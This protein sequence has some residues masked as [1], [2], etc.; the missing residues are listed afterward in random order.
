MAGSQD[1]GINF[2][3]N[4]Y[5]KDNL[6]GITEGIKQAVAQAKAAKDASDLWGRS[7]D[8]AAKNAGISVK[9][10]NS[11][12]KQQARDI[13]DA[14]R[15]TEKLAA[16]Q[17][18][19]A[20]AE[21]QHRQ[22]IA[23]TSAFEAANRRAQAAA[24][25]AAFSRTF[26]DTGDTV[27]PSIFGGGS[28]GSG[29]GRGAS[30]LVGR[31]GGR[32]LGAEVLGRGLGIPGG[33]FIG[34][35]LAYGAGLSGGAAL[36][37][38]AA[39]VGVVGAYAIYKDIENTVKYAEEQTK[40]AATLG[41]STRETQALGKAAEFSG[42]QI[43]QLTNVSRKLNDSLSSGGSEARKVEVT[44]K[45]LGLSLATAFKR[46]T[47]QL[48]DVFAALKKIDSIPERGRLLDRLFGPTEGRALLGAVDSYKLSRPG[49]DFV[50]D[51]DIT[52]LKQFGDNAKTAWQNVQTLGRELAV[53]SVH[54]IDFVGNVASGKEFKALMELVRGLGNLLPGGSTFNNRFVQGAQA[55][56]NEPYTPINAPHGPVTAEEKAKALS[57]INAALLPGRSSAI[58]GLNRDIAR[59][60]ADR[61]IAREKA[62]N[63][64]PGYT[65]SSVQAI[66]DQIES[67]K[68]QIRQQ[69][70]LENERESLSEFDIGD[71]EQEGKSAA[72]ALTQRSSFK[73]IKQIGTPGDR[74]ALLGKTSSAL[75]EGYPTLTGTSPYLD[76]L[77]RFGEQANSLSLSP[78]AEY[79][80]DQEQKRQAAAKAAAELE[81][82][83]RESVNDSI[84]GVRAQGVEGRESAREG[85]AVSAGFSRYG[86]RPLQI[87]G[88]EQAQTRGLALS[89][90]ANSVY[91]LQQQAAIASA[92]AGQLPTDSLERKKLEQ[93]VENLTIEAK[94]KETDAVI[95]VVDSIN[96]F[97]EAVD[98]AAEAIRSEFAGGFA[99]I[100]LGAQSGGKGAIQALKGFGTQQ[101]GIVLRN[102][103]EK[104]YDNVA[105]KTL[106]SIGAKL[107]DWLVK[108]TVLENPQEKIKVNTDQ[109]KD[110]VHNILEL[111]R[112]GNSVGSGTP[113][114]GLG[115]VSSGTGG[116]I[117]GILNTLGGGGN[118]GIFSG[119]SNNGSI[120]YGFPGSG[121]GGLPTGSGGTAL[122]T[123]SK[124]IG[125]GVKYGTAALLG[126]EGVSSLVKGGA[127]NIASGISGVAGAA[128]ILDQEPISKAVLAGV[129]VV[130]GIVSSVLGDPKQKRAEQISKA[131]FGQ[132]YLA[133][134]AINLSVGSNGGYSD[135]DN[136]GAVRTSNFSPY[137]VTANA[138][139]DVPRRTIVPGH[140]ISTFGG[141]AAGTPGAIVT[142]QSPRV[143]GN[144]NVP[145]YNF[146]IVAMDSKSFID[147]ADSITDA[148]HRGIQNQGHPL[149]NQL[150][151]Q[152]GI[153]G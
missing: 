82:Q 113:G 27:Y 134:E 24:E 61:D 116:G 108:G 70:R 57:D 150:A 91:N 143:A 100:I 94:T 115:G 3:I 104:I 130:S 83:V 60:E 105:K 135:F 146:T 122:S 81:R 64:Q 39:A 149:V 101:E 69:E 111:L 51:T 109:I 20:E 50:S 99:N 151:Q 72:R 55:S 18:K 93:E 8:L 45:E 43:D 75:S 7:L 5:G 123:F 138:F 79:Y 136:T 132:Q 124:A 13:D 148:V 41:L 17:R 114:K 90:G 84:S 139:Q 15:A 11:Q 54:A 120:L 32:V 144:A 67:K 22:L 31:V 30:S 140:T 26:R 1:Y 6:V 48:D 73:T 53:A 59:L 98:R 152:L 121:G 37:L 38:G 77:S 71:T 128:A 25:D 40:L 58:G 12:F 9:D 85:A 63:F 141:T 14:R 47:E 52:R 137:P 86:L 119:A 87:A 74:A 88:I 106:G 118:G 127:K 126:Y 131:L 49:E 145:T 62:V 80:R 16:E 147:H 46:P 21:L 110:D 117:Q 36:G 2:L 102:I 4:T 153:R 19:M 28:G 107:P 56:N 29:G 96:K 23:R 133:P 112:Q 142:P 97:N 35:Q 76:P 66:T 33:G 42:I 129:A 44:L 92:G 34:S 68:K 103:G 78:L 95:K 65:A 89:E 10:L 125:D